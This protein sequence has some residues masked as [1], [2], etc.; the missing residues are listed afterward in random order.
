MM[1]NRTF[2]A[3]FVLLVC[4]PQAV[5]AQTLRADLDR[6]GRPET[7][8]I[9]GPDSEHRVGLRIRRPGRETIS[10]QHIGVHYGSDSLPILALNQAGSLLIKTRQ[11]SPEI[12]AH[13][14]LT[15]A[16]RQRMYRV[17]GWTMGSSEA[18][19]PRVAT[20]CDINFVTGRSYVKAGF[21]QS[22]QTFKIPTSNVPLNRWTYETTTTSMCEFKY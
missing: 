6:D 4:L 13:T 7:I 3:F 2:L 14:T 8:T 5:E 11:D 15:I 21:P 20:H 18:D 16:F 22:R 12:K 10:A 9:I 19:N 1:K 17:A